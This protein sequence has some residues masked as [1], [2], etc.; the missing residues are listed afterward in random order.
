MK[1][2]KHICNVNIPN[3]LH[4]LLEASILGD[5]DDTIDSGLKNVIL[6]KMKNLKNSNNV[7][8]GIELLRQATENE[9]TIDNYL[10]IKKFNPKDF[11]IAI[12]FNNRSL[13][14]IK[15][16]TKTEYFIEGIEVCGYESYVFSKF[17]KFNEL[18]K[19]LHG[20][21]MADLT[22]KKIE[23]KENIDICQA[24]LDNVKN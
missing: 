15:K 12:N 9:T 10:D 21:G 20:M 16:N 8:E 23:S 7:E 13:L 5:I 22:I 17:V 1:S 6:S 18:S 3:S 11:I 2:L 19:D 24:I 14:V 4:S